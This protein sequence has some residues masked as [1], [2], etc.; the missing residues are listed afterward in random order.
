MYSNFI[1][2]IKVIAI[3]IL[4][5][6][7]LIY[8]W[9]TGGGIPSF[10]DLKPLSKSHK[11]SVTAMMKNWENEKKMK[12]KAENKMILAGLKIIISSILSRL[13]VLLLMP[14]ALLKKFFYKFS[15]RRNIEMGELIKDACLYNGVPE[16]EYNK[17]V[18]NRMDEAKKYAVEL[19]I[20]PDYHNRTWESC[21]TR[22]IIDLY[23]IDKLVEER[24][25]EIKGITTDK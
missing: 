8:F 21:L 9:I 15:G 25:Q 5:P 7:S 19:Q 1:V 6:W 18:F 10:E 12:K 22:A 20:T 2:S 4:L 13:A 16:V 3:A 23:M 24:M 17:I 11:K 14:F